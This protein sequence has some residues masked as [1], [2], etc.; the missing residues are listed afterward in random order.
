[1]LK[2]GTNTRQD[3]CYAE[4][5]FKH[6]NYKYLHSLSECT[7]FGQNNGNSTDTIHVLFNVLEHLFLH[8]LQLHF[9]EWT[10]VLNCL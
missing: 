1:M 3:Y 4:T 6:L 10:K 5:V 7:G 8:L 9:L 2:R